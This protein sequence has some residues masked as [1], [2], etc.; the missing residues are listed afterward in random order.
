MAVFVLKYS[1]SAL[2]VDV[3]H[4]VTIGIYYTSE[5]VLSVCPKRHVSANFWICIHVSRGI[6]HVCEGH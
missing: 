2:P 3:F 4:F 6:L 5:R 1:S